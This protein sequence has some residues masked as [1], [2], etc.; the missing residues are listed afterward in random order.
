M[1]GALT[2]C[3]GVGVV[4]GGI[5]IAQVNLAHETIDLKRTWRGGELRKK[6]VNERRQ[7]FSCREKL[8]NLD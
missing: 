6:M 3:T 4:D 2:P 1:I 5:N 7:T 8:A